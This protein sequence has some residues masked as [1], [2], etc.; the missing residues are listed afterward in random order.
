MIRYASAG[1]GELRFDDPFYFAMIQDGDLL[2]A[3]DGLKN[4][5]HPI[6]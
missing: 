1:S 3:I 4:F 5:I 2:V 6:T